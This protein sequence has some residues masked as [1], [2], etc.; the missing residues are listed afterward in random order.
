MRRIAILSRAQ[1]ELESRS[2]FADAY[3]KAAAF[4]KPVIVSWAN[5]DGTCQSGVGSFVVVN[6]DGWILTA[7]HIVALL[8][9]LGARKK[10]YTDHQAAAKAITDDPGLLGDQKRKKLRQ[11][12]PMP[13][14]AVISFSFWWA[15]DRVQPQDFTSLVDADLAV[16]RLQPF[17]KASVTTYPVFKNPA[18]PV[19]PGTSLCR[20]G[21]PFH[22]ITPTFDGQG[23]HLPPNTMP[24]VL[25]PIEGILTRELIVN[26]D[27]KAFV[28]FIETSSP[29][30][31]GQSGGPIFD[32]DGVIW[33]IQSQTH[34]LPLGFSP[35][36]P[37][38]RPGEKEHQFLNVGVGT[39]PATIINVLTDLEVAHIV[40]T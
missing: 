26:P 5:A 6:D 34:H 38:G 25:F 2:V 35:P 28:G 37:N 3:R 31:M 22:Q 4:T 16:G 29:G 8:D 32:R 33:G 15:A 39:H 24:M 17:D 20:L 10:A 7:H 23:F 27:P 36:V 9:Q 14:D 13:K 1:R 18:N 21:F 40:A 11:L 19:A 30:L 12:G